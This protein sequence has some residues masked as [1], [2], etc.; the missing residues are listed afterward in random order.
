MHFYRDILKRAWQ[1]TFRNPFLWFFGLF[2]ALAGN[3]EEYDSFFNN[4]KFVGNTQLNLDE[5]IAAR[6]DGRWTEFW[7]N[8]GAAFGDNIGSIMLIVLA[9]LVALFLFACIVTISQASLIRVASQAEDGKPISFLDS[10]TTGMRCFWK[11]LGLNITMLLSIY[12]PLVVIGLPVLFI[13]LAN[14]SVAWA[15]VLGLLI[16]FLLIP[17]GIVVAFLTKYAAAFI[18]I[19]KA[20]VYQSVRLAWKLF[21]RNWLITI[22]LGL[23]L[24]IINVI[25]TIVAVSVLTMLGM[26]LTQT[27]VVTFT[28][29]MIVLGSIFTVFRYT[30]WTFLFRQILDDKGIAKL[31]RIFKPKAKKG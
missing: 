3:G 18:V 31:E 19:K 22:E 27:G 30:A 4:I 11:L 13:Y 23:L 20:G 21:L 15:M 6:A 24:L 9:G 25:Y 1:L 10:F 8:I 5:L 14:P 26:P 2:A 29:I 7:D 28:I 12:L 17:V 16:F